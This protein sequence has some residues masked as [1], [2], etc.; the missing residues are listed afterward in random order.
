M[1]LA[2]EA[3]E[4]DGFV[5]FVPKYQ[6]MTNMMWLVVLDI[7][8]WECQPC[9]FVSP[10]H[11]SLLSSAFSPAITAKPTGPIESLMSASAASCFHDLPEAAISMFSKDLGLVPE[12]PADLYSKLVALIQCSRPNIND[13]ELH[14]IMELRARDKQL[15]SFELLNTEGI[16][17]FLDDES[18]KEVKEFKKDF[19]SR[20]AS[21]KPY[22]ER[23]KAHGEKV[24]S[25][26][27]EKPAGRARK[28]QKPLNPGDGEV[29]T[30]EMAKQFLPADTSLCKDFSNQ[31]WL[32]KRNN[33]T[34]SRSFELYGDFK[35]MCLCLHWAWSL[36]EAATNQSCPFP[37]IQ[38]H[39]N[40][41]T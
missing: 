34:R 40:P 23:L 4:E 26:K 14:S 39:S 29:F 11:A 8:D 2:A 1:G 17:N 38:Q 18:K 19:E 33:M 10:L 31:R 6:C 20:A 15:D 36:H 32:I 5:Y 25:A 21:A 27:A 35:A 13:V 7:K 37:F 24:V 3:K 9:T 12:A 30:E 28:K 22:K 16:Y 41:E